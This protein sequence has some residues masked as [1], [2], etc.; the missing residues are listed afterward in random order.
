MAHIFI[1]YAHTDHEYARKLA[2]YL[3]A[4]GFDV[5]IDDRI[6]FGTRWVR[7]IFEALDSCAAFIVVMT[8]R[9]NDSEFVE[10]EY[11]RAADQKKPT[12]PL[13]LEGGAFPYFVGIQYHDVR[14]GK[15]PGDDFLERLAKFVP[16]ANA[17]GH[18]V[19][20][21][22]T[23][24]LKQASKTDATG[25]YLTAAKAQTD[26]PAPPP[27]SSR[28]ASRRTS[29]PLTIGV[30]IVAFA[31]VIAIVL[32]S[33]LPASAS[34][35][36]TA[37][38]AQSSLNTLTLSAAN[39]AP[40]ADTTLTDTPISTVT[41]RSIN[42]LTQAWLEHTQTAEIQNTTATYAQART[43][44]ADTLTAA[45]PTATPTATPIGGGHGQILFTAVDH[46]T[47]ML[48][49]INAD[50]TQLQR[51]TDA[52]VSRSFAAWSPD[53]KRI[54]FI[55][56]DQG[57]FRQ[58]YVMNADGCGVLKLAEADV[59]HDFSG[60]SP[61]GSQIMYTTFGDS[62]SFISLVNANGSNPHSAGS[63]AILFAP[64]WSPDGKHVAFWGGEGAGF[65]LYVQDVTGVGDPQQITHLSLQ[66]EPGSPSFNLPVWSPDGTQI[67]F[68]TSSLNVINAD[69]SNL[70]VLSPS[71]A[72]T[73][74]SPSAVWSPDGR[75][76]A[77]VS[78]QDGFNAI[79]L[80]NPDGSNLHR[81]VADSISTYSPNWSPD[82]R[83]IVFVSDPSKVTTS[84]TVANADGSGLRHLF[85]GESPAWSPDGQH[86]AF[87]VDAGGFYGEIWLVNSD[88]SSP[89][90]LTNEVTTG[91]PF[92]WRP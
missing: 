66:N 80:V 67:V 12:F 8:P 37:Q 91:A 6:D 30:V 58:I 52:S 19:A 17:S 9:S 85:N 87:V 75:Q 59:P 76:I 11:L 3:L 56:T 81:L 84:V 55:T 4:H 43:Q 46:S 35:T 51:L 63:A 14:G 65:D 68:P 64:A 57:A 36:A 16:P 2:D 73:R 79:Y 89:H 72:D 83:Q 90:V 38:I 54:V 50:G 48:Y 70:R 10:K 61:D 24:E 21:T 26:K 42:P 62:S 5:W 45:I 13:L 33:Q 1:S 86:I 15:L 40:A 28:T 77:F 53:G 60:W 34:P 29:L 18:D 23:Q 39:T 44:V 69:G 32:R 49:L 31:I 78:K 92:A 27:S 7:S 88:G 74:Y 71:P 41:Q 47:R 25:E 20:T 22:A 82:S